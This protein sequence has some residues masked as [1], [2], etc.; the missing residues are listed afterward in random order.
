MELFEKA[1]F[2]SCR[3]AEARAAAAQMSDELSRNAMLALAARYERLA[4][5]ATGGD[6]FGANRSAGVDI[7]RSRP[8]ERR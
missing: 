8:L 3:A 2:W 7:E 1:E 5:R 6:V 4:N